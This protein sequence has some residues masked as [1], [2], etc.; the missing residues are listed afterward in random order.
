MKLSLYLPVSLARITQGFSENANES[1]AKTGLI[2]HTTIDWAYEHGEPVPNLARNAFC[3]SVMNRDNPDPDKYRAVFTLVNADNGLSDW[4]EIS[5]G[6]AHKVLAEVGKTYQVGDILMTAGNSGTVYAKGKLVTKAQKL[7][8]SKAGTHLHGP[9][10]RP[11][12]RVK[13]VNKKRHYLS[14]GSGLLKHDGWYY[15]IINYENGT[16]GCISPMPFM[17]ELTVADY[18]AGLKKQV[19]L[20][21]TVLALLKQK[22]GLK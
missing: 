11:V 6:H 17:K 21:S 20:L 7:A 19:S 2:G 15:E 18:M 1:Y 22:L 5:Y 14:D 9:Q 4:A 3:Y 13:T 16:N 10:V 8:G 12:R